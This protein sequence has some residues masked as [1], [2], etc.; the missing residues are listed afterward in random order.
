MDHGGL[1]RSELAQVVLH[2]GPHEEY[3]L[4]FCRQILA[5]VI[6]SFASSWA[7]ELIRRHEHVAVAPMRDVARFAVAPSR[8]LAREASRLGARRAQSQFTCRSR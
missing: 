3:L 7:F 4:P 5:V 2:A 6:R 1:M 8:D